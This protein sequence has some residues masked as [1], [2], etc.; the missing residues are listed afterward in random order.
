MGGDLPL[1][2]KIISFDGFE[3]IETLSRLYF[4]TGKTSNDLSVL[5]SKETT[6]FTK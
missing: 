2:E 6:A 5:G 3:N 4:N 1:Y